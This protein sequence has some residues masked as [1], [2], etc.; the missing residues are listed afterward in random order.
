Y[1]LTFV[2]GAAVGLGLAAKGLSWLLDRHH[3][4]T[5][6]VLV[7]LL[8]GSLR[9][10]WPWVGRVEHA[11]SDG[12][13]TSVPDPSVLLAP[14]PEWPAALALALAGFAFVTALAWFGRR[15]IATGDAVLAQEHDEV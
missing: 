6:A 8:A 9:A 11:H 2:S 12:S 4:L 14:G 7:G 1:V 3:D 13:V 5:M 10:L 15:R